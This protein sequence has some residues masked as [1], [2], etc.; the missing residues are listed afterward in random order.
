MFRWMLERAAR[1][2]IGFAVRGAPP[3]LRTPAVAYP[4]AGRDE[5][6]ITW[7]G[8]SSF[9]I[10]AGGLNVLTDP[11]WGDRASP[12]SWAGPRRLVPPGLPFDAL[13]PIDLVLQSHDHYDHLCDSTVRA[14][15]AHHPS[16]HWFAPLG[17]GS[18]LRDRGVAHV[19]ER[20]WHEAASIGD[21]T[22]T[23]VPARHFSGRSVTNRNHSL[24]AGW[25]LAT[26]PYRL[27]FAGDSG[28]H[29]DF[30]ELGRRHGPFDAV[31]MPIGAYD[32][33]WFMQPVHLD[34]E[35][36]VDAFAE[37]ADPATSV[38]I[39]MHWGTFVLTD[40]PVDEPPLRARTAWRARGFDDERLWVMAP[41]ETRALTP[42][43]I[44]G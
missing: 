1:G 6:R 17:V 21:A 25:V 13:P 12:L 44:S 16:A 31:L 24:W 23:C 35:E 8:H 43:R 42:N 5:C 26:G 34:P 9:L 11:M 41:G 14:L 20:D 32:P 40:E 3:R 2:R 15:A 7:I 18:Q 39:A 29:P 37:A 22:V 30:A 19:T 33:R 28:K 36:A 38:M 10:Q 4:R 27:Y